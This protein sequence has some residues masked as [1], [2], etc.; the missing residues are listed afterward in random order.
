MQIQKFALRFPHLSDAESFLNCVKDL[1]EC[2]TDSMDI[3]PSGSD[4]LCEDSSASEY[5]ASSGIHRPHDT[6]SFEEPDQAIHR[7]ETPALGYHEEPDEPIHRIEAPALSQHE[8]PALS[9]HEAPAFGQH[10]ASAFGHHEA[11]AFGHHQ[12]PQQILQPV[13][14]TNIDT[15]FSGFPPSFTDML[16][17]FSCKLDKVATTAAKESDASK[18]TDDIMTRMKTYM[19]DG[20]FH[21]MLYKLDKVI[22]ELGGDL[23]L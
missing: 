15:I 9:Q 1:K 6:I 4:Y 10:E 18:E 16:T 17:Q 5:I 2:S 11:P 12:A 8:A 3:I 20:A 22:D 13:L 19:A 21:D 23:S 7:T 14:A